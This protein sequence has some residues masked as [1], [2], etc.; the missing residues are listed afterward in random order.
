MLVN[1]CKYTIER[2]LTPRFLS[3]FLIVTRNMKNPERKMVRGHAI[4]AKKK[5]KRALGDG[6][7]R[8]VS[9]CVFWLFLCFP[10]LFQKLEFSNRSL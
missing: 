9:H 5:Q 1:I 2:A 8:F 6:L 10:C 7:L 3:R 4:F